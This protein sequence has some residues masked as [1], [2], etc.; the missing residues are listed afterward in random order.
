M[1]SHLPE[2]A[3]QFLTCNLGGGWHCETL[4]GGGNNRLFVV[5]SAQGQ[6][7][8]LKTYPQTDGSESERFRR[9]TSTLS[10]LAKQGEASVPRLL[11]SDAENG[12][13]LL[14]HVSGVRPLRVGMTDIKAAAAFLKRLHKLSRLVEA[15]ELGPA[16]EN[17]L[18]E[19]ALIDQLQARLSKLR[20]E[21]LPSLQPYLE[22]SIA[23][24]LEGLLKRHARLVKRDGLQGNQAR[25]GL[26]T[27]SPSDFSLHNALRC[28]DG[29][30][31]F[32]DF[33]YFGWDDPVK[34]VAETVWHPGMNLTC[35]QRKALEDI[36]LPIYSEDSDFAFR[37]ARCR[38]LYLLRWAFI[39]LNEFLPKRWE[40]RLRA[41]WTGNQAEIL[42][43]QLRKARCLINAARKMAL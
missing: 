3:R 28:P 33:E 2:A 29:R 14:E 21:G 31:V 4:T 37:L 16:A 25:K 34:L 24:L 42:D 11:A 40:A 18:Q 6:R 43:G 8:V 9:E 32:L 20:E 41:G 1:T 15:H 35:R 12:F 26:A 10:F 38:P 36:L 7:A 13:L 27:L 23:P 39:V 5:T 22:K 17:C 19:S 30:V